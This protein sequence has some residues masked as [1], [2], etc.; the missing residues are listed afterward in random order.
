MAQGA[1]L[2]AAGYSRR[3][4]GMKLNAAL[5][6]D[7]T[8]FSQSLRRLKAVTDNILVVTRQELLDGGL[9]HPLSP[10][11]R[12]S[13]RTICCAGAESG[14]GHSLAAGIAEMRDTD[15]CLICLSDMPLVHPD[16]LQTLFNALHPE[17]ITVPLHAGHRGNPA[18]FGK[19]FYPL[20]MQCS[21]DTGARTIIQSHPERVVEIPVSDQGIFHDI[22]TPDDL[23]VNR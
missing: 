17:R 16:T 22:D 10:I 3:F 5:S 6:E 12:R 1:L 9:L 11:E 7:D 23:R 4:G 20:L 21:G 8:V 19:H 15:A 18:G 14:L 13:L 2:L